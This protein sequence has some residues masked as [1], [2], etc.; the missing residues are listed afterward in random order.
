MFYNEGASAQAAALDTMASLGADTIRTLVRWRNFAPAPSSSKPPKKFDARVPSNYLTDRWNPLDELV[1]GAQA[2][3]MQV[4]LTVSG[5]GPDWA[6]HCSK[7][8]R[9]K[10]RGR[11]RPN[12]RLFGQF[13]QALGRRYSGSYPDESDGRKLPRVSRWSI[14]NEPNLGSWLYP[15]T[16]RV[17][18]RTVVTGAPTYRNLVYAATAGLKAAGHGHDQVLLG[19]TAPMGNGSSQTA[20]ARFYRELFCVD[21]HGRRLTG[22]AA[23]DSGCSHH[24][25]RL[26]VTGVAH[27]PY[28][29]GSGTQFFAK[30]G[31]DD[32]NIS[33]LSRLSAVMHMGARVGVVPGSLASSIYLTE[34]GVSTNP[35]AK[36][37]SVPPLIQAKMLNQADYIA[38]RNRNVR[39][40]AQYE[41]KDDPNL[42]RTTFQTGLCFEAS[43]CDEKL[44]FRSY[45]VPL[46][47]VRHGNSVS[48]FG[49]ARPGDTG[50]AEQIDIQRDDGQSQSNF[51]TLKTVPLSS[52]GWFTATLPYA[53]G[54]WRLVW[55]PAAGGQTFV[56]RQAK[57]ETR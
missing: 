42:N 55:T 14:W 6:T 24:P 35:P 48:I 34:F 13:A 32:I 31:A 1:R 11:C 23:S 12:T 54:L 3:G 17:R 50:M 36:R 52:S 57:A 5:P 47:V 44:S 16:Q 15:Q 26:A 8:E 21:S 4:L 43:P 7:S 29:R 46:Y 53:P 40:V 51:T 56:S 9:R 25:R 20:P 33:N 41:L 30:V 22:R 49:G 27:H 28:T 37:F 2:R 19:E 10:Y 39:S 38:Y 45:R 18:R